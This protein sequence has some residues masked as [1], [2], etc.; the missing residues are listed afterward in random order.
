MIDAFIK[1]IVE[2]GN[3][4]LLIILILCLIIYGGIKL[5]TRLVKNSKQNTKDIGDIKKD[6]EEILDDIQISIDNVEEQMRILISEHKDK[7]KDFE[8]EHEKIHEKIVDNLETMKEVK[9]E[10][11]NLKHKVEL[12]I[13]Q[14]NQYD[15]KL[16]KGL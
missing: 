10:L 12:M 13:V 8:H 16:R 14:N 6:F 7:M 3:V 1:G 15:V 2:T 5:V 4:P 9:T 11:V